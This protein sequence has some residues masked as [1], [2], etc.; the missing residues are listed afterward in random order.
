MVA[1][2]AGLVLNAL[3]SASAKNKAAR[4]NAGQN[5]AINEQNRTEN[6]MGDRM[7]ANELKNQTKSA[8][9]GQIDA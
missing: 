1:A 9:Y 7:A 2:V 6:I 5:I 8:N 3:N 4:A